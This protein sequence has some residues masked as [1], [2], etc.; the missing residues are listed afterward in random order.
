MKSAPFP[1][2]VSLLL[3]AVSL[4]GCTN[5]VVHRE[6]GFEDYRQGDWAA[7]AEDF[8]K[9]VDVKPADH[10]SQYYLGAALLKQGLAVQAQTPLEQ[11]LAVRTEDPQWTPRIA[12][13]LAETYYQQEQYE[14]LYAFLDDMIATYQQDTY[15]FLRKAKYLGLM[16]DADGQQT[17]LRK[18][19][20]FAPEGDAGPY[21]AIADFYESVNDIDN[22]LQALRYG[23]YVDPDNEDVKDRLRGLGV[24]PGPTIADAPPKPELID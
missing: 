10:Q 6:R 1:S 5:H 23:Y 11:A 14:K 19:A 4:A 7:A 15:D 8:R 21:L 22:T 18:A 3:L 20:F 12:D 9:A 13:L 17:A 2:A 16:G 24:I